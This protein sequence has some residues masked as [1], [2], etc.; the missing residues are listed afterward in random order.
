MIKA[1]F[2]WFR[3]VKNHMLTFG[4]VNVLLLF[5]LYS[6]L[7]ELFIFHID[8]LQFLMIISSLLRNKF[9]YYR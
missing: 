1:K 5:T 9:N 6:M 8:C 7:I 3:N 4:K 2:I